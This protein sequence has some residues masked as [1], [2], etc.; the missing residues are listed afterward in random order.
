MHGNGNG[1]TNQ[2][3]SDDHEDTEL[4]PDAEHGAQKEVDEE[5]TQQVRPKPPGEAHTPHPW[6]ILQAMHKSAIFSFL[7]LKTSLQQQHLSCMLW[8]VTPTSECFVPDQTMYE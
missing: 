6:A 8:P 3:W 7:T 2:G 1:F 4:R 5:Y